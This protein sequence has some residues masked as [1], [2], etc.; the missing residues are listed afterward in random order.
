[1]RW[2]MLI[3]VIVLIALWAVQGQRHHCY[4]GLNAS[5]VHCLLGQ[6]AVTSG[7]NKNE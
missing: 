3:L 6:E 5:Y 7:D 4:F 2:L 1:M